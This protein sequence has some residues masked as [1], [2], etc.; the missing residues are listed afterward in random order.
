[1]IHAML[2]LTAKVMAMGEEAVQH[3]AEIEVL[4]FAA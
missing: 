1:M 4:L 2:Q 3:N